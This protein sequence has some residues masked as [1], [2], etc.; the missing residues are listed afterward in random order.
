MNVQENVCIHLNKIPIISVATENAM[1]QLQSH[2][3][4]VRKF[5]FLLNTGIVLLRNIPD[6]TKDH[7]CHRLH[8][9]CS[10]N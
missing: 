2:D 9:R 5:E 10:L 4:A 1:R 6:K 8:I 3:V 7:V